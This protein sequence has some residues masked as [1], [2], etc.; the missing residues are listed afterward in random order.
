MRKCHTDVKGAKNPSARA[1]S[2]YT[3]DGVLVKVY[4]Y[5]KIAA[6]EKQVDLSSIIKCCRG[7]IKTCK[8][9]VWKYAEPG[10]YGWAEV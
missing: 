6:E 5:A 1:V 4:Q 2:C 3:K 9:F 7:K 10:V 8:G